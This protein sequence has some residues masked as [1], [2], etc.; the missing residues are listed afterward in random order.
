[1]ETLGNILGAKKGEK[2]QI[3]FYC[4]KCDFNCFKK[5]SWDRHLNTAKHI[6]ETNGSILETQKGKK[7]QKSSVFTPKTAQNRVNL[8]L[9]FPANSRQIPCKFPDQKLTRNVPH[10]SAGFYRVLVFGRTRN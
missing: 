4:E 8:G 9:K 5:Y 3:E 1:M 2:G 7:G 6:Q 10:I